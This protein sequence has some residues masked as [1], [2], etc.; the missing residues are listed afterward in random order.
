MCVRACVFACAHR[1]SSAGQVTRHL[2]VCVHVSTELCARA[3]VCLCSLPRSDCWAFY[4][5]TVHK[6]HWA[7][8]G[9]VVSGVQA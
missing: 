2:F 1:L 5:S 9:V 4:S 6:D 7:G 8:H 3:R